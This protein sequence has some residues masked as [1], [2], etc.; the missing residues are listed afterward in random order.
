[1]A[2]EHDALAGI[3]RRNL[4]GIAVFKPLVRT[5]DLP[6]VADFLAE[7]AEFI[8]QAVADG[9]HPQRCHRVHV[10]GREAPQTAI[11]QPRFRLF[12]ANRIEI[13][14]QAAHCDPPRR[15]DAEIQ[16]RVHEVWTQQKL[17]REITNHPNVAILVGL[18]GVDPVIHD[19]VP[20]Q[21]RQRMV[22]VQR[23]G[24]LNGLAYGAPHVAKKG[25]ANALGGTVVL[26]RF[27][28]PALWGIWQCKLRSC[29]GPAL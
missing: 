29:G 26:D 15:G 13:E 14:V 2:A 25:G 28:L 17:C 18:D 21:M 9:R 7:D 3:R 5:L 22:L 4:P 12:I 1:M 16:H 20:Y 8:A 11:A 27:S 24:K 6:A 23:C 19:P 10:A